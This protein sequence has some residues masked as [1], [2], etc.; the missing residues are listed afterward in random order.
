MRDDQGETIDW[1]FPW[2]LSCVWIYFSHSC[3]KS[4]S[5]V[6]QYIPYMDFMAEQVSSGAVSNDAACVDE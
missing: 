6:V 4:A 5:L 1:L 2:E 3:H